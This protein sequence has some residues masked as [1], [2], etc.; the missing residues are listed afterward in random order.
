MIGCDL[1]FNIDRIT[2]DLLCLYPGANSDP[3]LTPFRFIPL[4][5][6]QKQGEWLQTKQRE[7]REKLQY[8]IFF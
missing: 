5:E 1:L 4:T 6:V 8:M 7:E 2:F 3:V